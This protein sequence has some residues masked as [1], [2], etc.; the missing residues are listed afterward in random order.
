MPG[1]EGKKALEQKFFLN[2]GH[3]LQGEILHRYGTA[4]V[5]ESPKTTREET[6]RRRLRI[7]H[8]LFQAKGTGKDVFLDFLKCTSFPGRFG[9]FIDQ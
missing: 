7:L 5:F 8:I 1:N 3:E 9:K 4:I 6:S 2:F